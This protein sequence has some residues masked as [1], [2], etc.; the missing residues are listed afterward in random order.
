[1]IELR[2]VSFYFELSVKYIIKNIIDD[3][4]IVKIRLKYSLKS[5]LFQTHYS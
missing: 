2:L 3:T 1:M 5:N 4:L